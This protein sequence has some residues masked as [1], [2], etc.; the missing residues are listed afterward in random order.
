MNRILKAKRKKQIMKKRVEEKNKKRRESEMEIAKIIANEYAE[1]FTQS[2][3][4]DGEHTKIYVVQILAAHIAFWN[5]HIVKYNSKQN[6]L[7]GWLH[8]RRE[9]IISK[10][11]LYNLE[12]EVSYVVSQ[13]QENLES[14]SLKELV[15]K[16]T[17]T[18]SLKKSNNQDKEDAVDSVV[19]TAS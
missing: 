17:Q 15:D 7:L 16:I 1:L 12:R 4:D 3:K 13:L 9:E 10:V 5:S 2:E 14:V 18:E 11:K 19:T 8:E 6:Y